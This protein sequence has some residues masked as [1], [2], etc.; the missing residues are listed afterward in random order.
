MRRIMVQQIISNH[1]LTFIIKLLANFPMKTQY[2]E[3]LL[4]CLSL[5]DNT[6]LLE[7]RLSDPLLASFF[8]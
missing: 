6:N 8:S 3:E 5:R 4:I 1:M 2:E 7:D